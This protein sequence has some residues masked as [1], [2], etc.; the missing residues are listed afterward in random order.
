MPGNDKVKE[1]YI[2]LI[3]PSSPDFKYDINKEL[4]IKFLQDQYSN[5]FTPQMN[6]NLEAV[7]KIF[8]LCRFF[9][10]NLNENTRQKIKMVLYKDFPQFTVYIGH[11]FRDFLRSLNTAS[12]Y[13]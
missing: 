4:I 11:F 6:D 7:F 3:T 5:K 10:R 1:D 2:T 12:Q 13:W 8:N 9:Q